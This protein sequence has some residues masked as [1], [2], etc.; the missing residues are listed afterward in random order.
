MMMKSLT[1]LYGL[2]WNPFSPDIPNEALLMMPAIDHF[3]WRVEHLIREGGFAMITGD[4]GAGKSVALRLL[5]KR[6]SAQPDLCVGVLTRPQS[7]ISD[8]YREMSLMFG[9]ALTPHSRW[10]PFQALRQK[11]AAH[12]ESTHLRPVLLIDEAQ[13][14]NT[15]VLS[16]IRLLT[17][18]QFDSRSILTVVLCGDDRLTDRLREPAQ[19]PLAS[20]IRARL[21]LGEA[22]PKELLEWLRYSLEEAGQPHL[23]SAELMATLC[24][25]AAG[26]YRALAN[27]ANELLAAAVKREAKLL[28]EKLFFEVF[29]PPQKPVRRGA[30][31]EAAERSRS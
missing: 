17:S 12:I 21:T 26:N 31:S 20:R 22:Q 27:L 28:D 10:M 25:H 5:H 2:K 29:A 6:L 14:V 7:R 4:P 16:E 3:C 13:E 23:M 9:V 1:A 19:M 18:T 24:E 11:W 30:A 8:F 15:F